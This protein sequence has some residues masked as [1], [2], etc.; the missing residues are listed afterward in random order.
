M[1]IKKHWFSTDWHL[2]HKN[3]LKFD[4]RPFATIDEHDEHIIWTA[5]QMLNEGDNFYYLGDFGFAKKNVMEKFIVRLASTGANL[6]F[7][8]GNHDK[9]DT[10]ALYQK[11]GTYLGQQVMIN[12]NGQDIVLNHFKL[13]IW[14]KSHRGA[15]HLYGHSHGDAEWW[16]IGKS[17]DVAINVHDYKLLEFEDIKT[18]MDSREMH[19]VDHH[20]EERD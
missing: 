7:V 5:E 10:I 12:I 4:K 15:W 1:N 11:Y 13:A 9:S 2:K 18:I 14:E 20:G 6:F 19:K 16:K 3:I 17:M 8:K